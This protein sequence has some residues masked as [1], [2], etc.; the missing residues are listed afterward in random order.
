[1]LLLSKQLRA[2]VIVSSVITSFCY[3]FVVVIPFFAFSFPNFLSFPKENNNLTIACFKIFLGFFILV[4]IIWF[5][6]YQILRNIKK[7]WATTWKRGIIPLSL[8]LILPF[9]YNPHFYTTYNYGNHQIILRVINVFIVNI[10]VFHF[11]EL[12]IKKYTQQKLNGEIKKLSYQQLESKYLLEK[13]QV[14][15]HFIFNTLNSINELIIYKPV[16]AQKT[17]IHLSNFL[18]EIYQIQVNLLTIKEE[19]KIANDFLQ[20]QEVRFLKGFD[21]SINIPENQ[22]NN[23]VPFFTI[24]TLLENIFKHNIISEANPLKISIFMENE[25]VY[26][27]NAKNLKQAVSSNNSGLENL[28]IRCKFLTE[29]EITIFDEIDYFMVK[30]KTLVP[31]E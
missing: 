28:N 3:A 7:N 15:F 18:R 11:F 14:N 16:I 21:V 13:S 24:L 2:Q 1:M 17:I 22:T 25:Y 12:I 23:L 31:N 6:H 10:M 29:K 30:I 26:V 5:L 19:L 4:N 27:K 20:I 8:N 9:T